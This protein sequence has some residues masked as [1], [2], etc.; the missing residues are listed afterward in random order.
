MSE[1]FRAFSFVDR[2][3]SDEVGQR[4]AASYH[5]PE[6]IDS[7][8]LSLVG[9]AI[10]QCAAMSSMKAVDFRYRPVAGI[11]GAVEFC[12][13]V[14]PGDTL[15][16]EATLVKAD[17]EAVGYDGLATVN[18]EPVVRL[19]DCLGPMVPMDD[20]DDP[21]AVKARYDLLSGEGAEVDVFPGVPDFPYEAGEIV[22]GESAS[23]SFQIPE[24]APF[25]GDHFPRKPVFP[26]T[27]LMNLNLQFVLA[28]AGTLEGAGTWTP[29]GMRSMKLR[30]FMP[31]GESLSLSAE[32]EEIEGDKATILVQSRRGKRL[33]S[34]ARVLLQQT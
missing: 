11:A 34:S 1:H 32:V 16:L 27:L 22:A 14:K 17:E 2:I 33:N 9:E 15:E 6:G 4:I 21:E 20:F 12:G 19:R 8:P 3:H 28:L 29:T 26:G 31:P 13:G 10:G 7:F 24:S 18:G 5:I 30:A 23:G 25:F